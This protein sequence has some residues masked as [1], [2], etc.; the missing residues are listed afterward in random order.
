MNIQMKRKIPHGHRISA[1]CELLL[2]HH[3]VAVSSTIGHAPLVDHV[4]DS[5]MIN[6]SLT[7]T[8]LLECFFFMSAVCTVEQTT[9][10]VQVL[11]ALESGVT[12]KHRMFLDSCSSLVLF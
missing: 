9:E 6:N 5:K 7:I 12:G 4:H 3:A 11:K 8:F 1:Q 2:L 10:T